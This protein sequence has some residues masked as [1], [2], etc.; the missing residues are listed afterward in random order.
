MIQHILTRYDTLQSLAL[1]YLND[2]TLWRTIADYNNLD[3][4]Y[5]VGGT[6]DLED[7]YSSGYVT[8]VRNNYT[9]SAVIQAGWLF[10]TEPTSLRISASLFSRTYLS[11]N[12]SYLSSVS[13]IIH[14][15]FSLNVGFLN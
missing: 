3:Y 11:Q 8:V 7:F 10:K 13:T 4:P 14:E 6:T 1:Q 5:I 15:N 12:S 9:N 2:A